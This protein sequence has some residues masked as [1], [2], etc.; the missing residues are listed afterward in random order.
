[1]S[2]ENITEHLKNNFGE[3]KESKIKEFYRYIK[4]KFRKFNC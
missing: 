1:M 4:R 3:E 2:E